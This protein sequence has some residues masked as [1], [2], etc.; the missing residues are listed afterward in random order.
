[1]EKRN[2][3]I[4]PWTIPEIVTDTTLDTIQINKM[5]KNYRKNKT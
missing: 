5:A 3:S 1:M 4:P 2:N